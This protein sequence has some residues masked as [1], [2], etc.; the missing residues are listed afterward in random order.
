MYATIGA[1]GSAPIAST[2]IG[3]S[4]VA[5]VPLAPPIAV[6]F[7][8]VPHGMVGAS[9]VGA[10][11]IAANF[12]IVTGVRGRAS[13]I[14][15]YGGTVTVSF[16]DPADVSVQFLSPYVATG[17]SSGLTGYKQVR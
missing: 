7:T 8:F 10:L 16:A 12:A 1:V 14:W 2:A 6:P 9:P 3:A 13:F 17:F 4:G 5:I 15:D 11:P